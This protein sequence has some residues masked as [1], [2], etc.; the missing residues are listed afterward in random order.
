MSAS[1]APESEEA[2]TSTTPLL[3]PEPSEVAAAPE[4]A[5]AGGAAD[6]AEDGIVLEVGA[7]SGVTINAHSLTMHGGKA[8]II[9]AAPA[10]DA[11]KTV[12]AL[13]I[14]PSSASSTVQVEVAPV[15]VAAA[16]VKRWTPLARVRKLFRRP[17]KPSLK[18]FAKSAAVAVAVPCAYRAAREVLGMCRRALIARRF[19]KAMQVRTASHMPS[20]LM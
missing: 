14:V 20:A 8:V 6:G 7:D 15:P 1:A 3:A 17:Q 16:Q 5:V 13:M 2:S 19:N 11:L 4:T 9:Q 18:G 10:A 12:D